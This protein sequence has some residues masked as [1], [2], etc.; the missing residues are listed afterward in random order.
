MKND[1]LIVIGRLSYP[2]GT[3][4]SNRVHLYC[5][6]LK[7]EK[8]FPFVINLH[9][10]FTKPQS[11]NYLARHEGI[12][13]YYAQKTSVREN[14][15]LQRN[16]NKIKGIINS[17]IMI[18]RFKRTLNIKVLF[19]ATNIYCEIVFFVALKIMKVPIIRELNETPSVILNQSSWSKCKMGILYLRLKMYDDIIV[20]SDYLRHFY[21][22]KFPPDHIFQIPILVDM[23]RFFKPNTHLTD[24]KNIVTY[25][26]SMGGDKDGLENLIEAAYIIKERYQPIELQLI[27]SAQ[28]KDMARLRNRVKTLGLE[29]IVLFMGSKMTNEIPFCLAKSNFLVLARPNN[30]Q[31]KGGFPTKL[32][33][34]LASGKPV[35]ITRTGEISKY[36]RDGE[37]A[38]LSE[39]DNPKSFAEKL[40][41]ALNDQNAEKIGQNGRT[42]ADKNFNY[43][44]YGGKLIEII[45]TK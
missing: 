43:K 11:F 38:Y 12:P 33:E 18:N 19:F 34:Y 23:E 1:G 10:T 41:F 22:N 21:Q 29:N 7:R 26:G 14:R 35:V 20:I 24:K 32:G 13:F 44:L 25:V 28:S 39:P 27:G 3:A 40:I 37:S 42:I 36:L 45:R 9:S 17:L 8:G 5:K 4:P 30:N 6:A 15:L 2:N 16:I 31:A